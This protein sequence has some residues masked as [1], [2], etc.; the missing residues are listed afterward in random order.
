MV[1][2]NMPKQTIDS[3]TL[4]LSPT[5][6]VQ[7]HISSPDDRVLCSQCGE[8]IVGYHEDRERRRLDKSATVESCY[9]M[10]IYGAVPLKVH[11]KRAYYPLHINC[12]QAFMQKRAPAERQKLM[13]QKCRDIANLRTN[14]QDETTQHRD[15]ASHSSPR[16]A[17]ATFSE[18]REPPSHKQPCQA[19]HRTRGP[20][21][22]L[23]GAIA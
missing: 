2:V 3:R 12:Q 7:K 6:F 13:A 18:Q 17:Q 16:V 10:M 14:L 19:H 9:W 21:R 22:R 23:H 11:G 8:E 5:M 20:H 4:Q 15:N 1:K